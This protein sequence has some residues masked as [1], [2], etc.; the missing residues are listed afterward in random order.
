MVSISLVL[1]EL[2]TNAT[3]YGALTTGN[4][5][6]KIDWT[7]Q[8]EDGQD[9]VNLCWSERGGP[10]AETI[11]SGSGFGSSLIDHSVTRNLRGEIKRDWTAD[12]LLC[13]VV[14]P[15]PEDRAH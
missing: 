10:S 15:V 14:F 7:I 4:G 6:V 12:G 8:S 5:F 9:V 13:T 3:K 11:P 1:N 2:A